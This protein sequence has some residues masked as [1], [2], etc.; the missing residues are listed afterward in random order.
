M[1]ALRVALIAAVIGSIASCRARVAKDSP[2]RLFP[3]DV[4]IVF[5]VDVAKLRQTPSL[6][7]FARGRP[8]LAPIEREIGAFATATGFHPLNDVDS[9]A[10]AV[11]V[12]EEKGAGVIVRGR[13]LDEKRLVGYMQTS[14]GQ[15]D[16]LVSSRHGART[17]WSS[18]T[19]PRAATIFLDDE[20]LLFGFDG[21]AERMADLADG[22]APGRAA[23]ANARAVRSL[24][25]VSGHAIAGVI[26]DAGA[27]GGRLAAGSDNCP[28][29]REA[30]W[31]VDVGPKL[32]VHVDADFA[33]AAD[34]KAALACWRKAVGGD[35]LAS[36]KAAADG[37]KL[38]MDT[39]FDV[40]HELLE[41]LIGL[42]LDVSFMD[43]DHID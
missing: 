22:V 16:E 7:D 15:G 11:S 31:T 20:T 10:V 42:M 26:L 29:F 21:W 33:S 25:D 32:V 14:K 2:L 36:I 38:R 8:D 37:P 28:V 19:Q 35:P 5:T 1:S 43:F 23:A 3:A 13:H 9:V 4:G 39:G 17:L 24:A 6:V 18:R 12:K 40:D 30:A 41:K 27:I 34:A